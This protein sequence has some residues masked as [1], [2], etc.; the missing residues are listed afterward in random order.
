MDF[1]VLGSYIEYAQA[2]KRLDEVMDAPHGTP[3]A[4]ERKIL[5]QLFIQFERDIQKK[6]FYPKEY[7]SKALLLLPALSVV[8]ATPQ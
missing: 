3:E 6:S 4:E 1:K 2:A 5:I 8:F 7:L